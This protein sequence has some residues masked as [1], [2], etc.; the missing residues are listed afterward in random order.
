[1]ENTNKRELRNLPNNEKNRRYVI[2]EERFKEFKNHQAKLLS[3]VAAI[4]LATGL[5]AQ[6][7]IE[8][9]TQITGNSRNTEDA[10]RIA[11]SFENYKRELD[12]NPIMQAVVSL[13]EKIEIEK[14]EAAIEDYK[15][16]EYKKNR[17]FEEEER[18]LEASKIIASSS[19]MV[20]EFYTDAL[21]SKIAETK[22]IKKEEDI[23]EIEIKDYIHINSLDGPQ[24]TRIIQIPNEGKVKI[25]GNELKE[26]I[27]EAREGLDDEKFNSYSELDRKTIKSIIRRWREALDFIENYKIIETKR[28]KLKAVKVVDNRKEDMD[29]QIEE[30]R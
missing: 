1:M 25:T 3:R 30:E 8:K 11:A 7:V 14:L 28:G 26:R 20:V 19:N 15:K 2:S 5:T 22:K 23:Q 18:Y 21:R 13:E 24:H 27:T 12:N 10:I 4:F 16:L 9:I 17:T 6:P 29:N